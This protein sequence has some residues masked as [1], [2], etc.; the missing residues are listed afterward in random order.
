MKTRHCGDQ[1]VAKPRQADVDQ[2]QGQDHGYIVSH[3]N[4]TEEP[5]GVTHETS[6][7]I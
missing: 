7:G 6:P 3:S 1:I 2:R 5:V 4:W